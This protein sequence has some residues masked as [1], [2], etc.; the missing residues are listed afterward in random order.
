MIV[1]LALIA[2]IGGFSI[3]VIYIMFK[4]VKKRTTV[5][6]FV[7]QV[8][9]AID[10]VGP[11]ESGFVRFHGE[12]WKARSDYTV[13]PGQKVKIVAR[14]GLTLIVEPINENGR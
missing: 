12:Y 8:A 3:L 4:S 11:G 6:E 13:P 14:D 10:E 5:L 2:V 9:V 1:T 7:G